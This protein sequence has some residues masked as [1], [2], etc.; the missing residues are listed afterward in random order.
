VPPVVVVD[1]AFGV[2]LRCLRHDRGLSLRRLGKLI[3]Y[4]HTQVWELETGQAQPTASQAK[5]LDAALDAGV[6]RVPPEIRNSD[7]VGWY[8]CRLAEAHLA[9][10]L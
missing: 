3:N 1:P 4:S 5:S 9:A 2:T 8:V 10:L 7:W 6:A